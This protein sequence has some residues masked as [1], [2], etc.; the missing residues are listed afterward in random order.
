MF[1]LALLSKWRWICINDFNACWQPLLHYRYG[2]LRKF[3]TGDSSFKGSTKESLWQRDLLPLEDNLSVTQN[4]FVSAIKP[5]LG[6]GHIILLW[7]LCWLSNIPLQVSFPKLFV[8]VKA[9]NGFVFDHGFWFADRWYW[10]L[11]WDR[12][13]VEE[14]K[15]EKILLS[16]LFLVFI[17]KWWCRPCLIWQ[18]VLAF[19]IAHLHP[20][21]K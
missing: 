2:Y 4:L 10:K 17:L 13:L 6:D 21:I 15:S 1:N 7:Q 5:E 9:R 3:L 14:E 18:H 12:P 11:E 16:I 20:V 19:W 8:V